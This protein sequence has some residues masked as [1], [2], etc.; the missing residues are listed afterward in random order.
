MRFAG[1]FSAVAKAHY[2]DDAGVHG[3]WQFRAENEG[4]PTHP[5]H[6]HQIG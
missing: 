3:P 5:P 6:P 1:A 2:Q 4:S